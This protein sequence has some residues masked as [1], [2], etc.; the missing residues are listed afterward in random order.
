MI[1]LAV[2]QRNVRNGEAGGN[3]QM[4]KTHRVSLYDLYKRVSQA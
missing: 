1:V 2:P 4:P 3:G